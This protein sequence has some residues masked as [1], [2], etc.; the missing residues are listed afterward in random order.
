LN[1]PSGLMF[2]DLFYS[3][4]DVACCRDW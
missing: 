4:F 1:I 2:C 3:T